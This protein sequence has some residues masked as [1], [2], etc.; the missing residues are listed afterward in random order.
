M[1][2][3]AGS[4]LTTNDNSDAC[5]SL[6]AILGLLAKTFA[7]ALDTRRTHQVSNNALV[8]RQPPPPY[9]GTA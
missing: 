7:N 9:V 1:S 4:T 2:A 6:P 5:I 8:S 3:T